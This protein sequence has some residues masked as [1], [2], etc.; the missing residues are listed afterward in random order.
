MKTSLRQIGIGLLIV[1]AVF[2]PSLLLSQSEDGS[3]QTATETSSLSEEPEV[4]PETELVQNDDTMVLEKALT[5]YHQ[6]YVPPDFPINNINEKTLI[7]LA[8]RELI[9]RAD[10]EKYK[11][12]VYVDG[13]VYQREEVKPEEDNQLE[14]PDEPSQQAP[15]PEVASPNNLM[16]LL[17]TSSQY[18]LQQQTR[19]KAPGVPIR[20]APY[21]YRNESFWLRNLQIIYA[22]PLLPLP[23]PIEVKGKPG[24]NPDDYLSTLEQKR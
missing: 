2:M 14:I 18:M 9:K 21:E 16:G 13:K 15:P 20:P 22:I 4:P 5:N 1:M 3:D 23:K 24:D 6:E 19:G 7:M 11:D 8:R 10:I 12:M 17:D